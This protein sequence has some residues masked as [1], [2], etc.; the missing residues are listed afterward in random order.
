M[1]PTMFGKEDGERMLWVNNGTSIKSPRPLRITNGSLIHLTSNQMEDPQTSDVPQPI[2]DGG[3]YGE[4]K[5]AS[6]S[7]RKERF[8]KFNQALI[9]KCKTWVLQTEELT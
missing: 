6:L 7:M 9:K 1:V 8:W 2:Q 5:E 3:N 4:V